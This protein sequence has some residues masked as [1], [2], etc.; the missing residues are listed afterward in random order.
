[1]SNASCTLPD[2][3][4]SEC[5]HGRVAT[6]K[7]SKV[8][9]AP[10]VADLKQQLKKVAGSQGGLDLSEDAKAQA[11]DILNKFE[12]IDSARE[13]LNL[14]GTRWKAVFTN[15]TSTSAGKF[16]PFLGKTDQVFPQSAPGAFINSVELFGGLLRLELHGTCSAGPDNK[17][18]LVFG[19]VKAFFAKLPVRTII[20]CCA[21]SCSLIASAYRPCCTH[22]AEA[23]AECCTTTPTPLLLHDERSGCVAICSRRAGISALAS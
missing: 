14:T 17:V 2:R 7:A 19:F 20:D 11:V 12:T 5:R 9:N 3:I 18:Q 1:M 4:I 22:A 23:D 8:D 16:G 10:R 15:S 6:A 13:Q 21:F